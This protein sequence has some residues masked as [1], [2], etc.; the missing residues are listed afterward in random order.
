MEIVIVCGGFFGKVVFGV[1]FNRMIISLYDIIIIVVGNG[2]CDYIIIIVDIF[3]EVCFFV[4]EFYFNSLEVID[5]IF[6]DGMVVMLFFIEMVV[7]IV[8]VG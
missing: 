7:D 6:V 8:C 1:F 5:G 3:F 4:I 2:V